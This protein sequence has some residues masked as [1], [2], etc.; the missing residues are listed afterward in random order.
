[1][2]DRTPADGSQFQL[3]PLIPPPVRDRLGAPPVSLTSFVGRKREIATLT[4]F[5]RHSG[6]RLVTLTGPGGVGKTRL[7]LRVIEG[8]GADFADGVAFVP[9]APLTDPDLVAAT[10]ARVVGVREVRGRSITDLLADALADRHILLMLDNFEQVVT[11]VLLVPRLLA[12]CPDLVV[13][14]TSRTILR[15]SGEQLFP[16]SPLILPGLAETDTAEEVMAAEAVRLFVDRA[17]AA[18]PSFTLTT[19]NVSA[20]GEI[21]RRLDGL[22]LAIELAA[23]RITLLAPT[24]MLTRIERRLPLLTGGPCDAPA[25]LQTMRNAIAWSHELIS[26]EEQALFR[27]LG[28][29]SGGFTVDA[30]EAIVSDGG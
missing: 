16:V 1:M 20:I 25:R 18:D 2:A 11:A 28:V 6:A 19:H 23:A 26:A 9:L 3:V 27:R 5:L 14:V 8:L 13:L 30:A 29:F 10:I 17:R 12:A 7:A 24:A 21:C 15:V 22:P 4:S